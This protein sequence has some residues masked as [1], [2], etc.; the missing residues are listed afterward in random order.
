MSDL[1]RIQRDVRLDAL[2]TLRLAG[3]AKRFAEI[4]SAE[5]LVGLWHSREWGHGPALVL[6]G[7]SNLVLLGDVMGLVLHIAIR[8]FQVDEGMDAVRI[9]VGAGEN[10]DAV[11]KRTLA[12]GFGGLENLI[13]IPGSVGAAPVQNIGAYGLELSERLSEVTV[14]DC[15]SGTLLEMPSAACGFTY[16]DSVFRRSPGR[17]VI[18]GVGLRLPRPW[19]PVLGYG[20]L[21]SLDA[22]RVTPNEIADRV[23]AIRSEKLPDPAKVPNVGSF[24]KNPVV[25]EAH[26]QEIRA[27][28]PDVVSYPD[29]SGGAKLAAAWLI[30]ACGWKGRGIGDA[31]VHDR[32]AL[33]LINRGHAS[34]V[35][36]MALAAAIK[37]SVEERFGVALEREPVLV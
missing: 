25:S 19:T 15:Q 29:A 24:F 10:W 20:E 35:E 21:A 16:R 34:A 17:Y 11:V 26:L 30:E 27:T 13:S 9:A 22:S 31:A 8:G 7:G 5:E 28:H 36:V 1:P 18:V 37:A 12:L 4:E 33:V 32:Q 6:G 14:F 3:R 23:A 2:N